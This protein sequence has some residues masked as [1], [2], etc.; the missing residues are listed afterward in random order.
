M[1]FSLKLPSEGFSAIFYRKYP[2]KINAISFFV[3]SIE[4]IINTFIN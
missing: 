2:M 3:I 4:S 1:P